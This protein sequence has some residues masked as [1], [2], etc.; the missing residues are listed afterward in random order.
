MIKHTKFGTTCPTMSEHGTKSLQ[1]NYK[2]VF[3]FPGIAIAVNEACS[4]K[5]QQICPPLLQLL[6]AL[7][8]ILTL[9]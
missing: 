8:I 2:E 5:S 3:Q 1:V 9:K 6:K 4:L 7:S